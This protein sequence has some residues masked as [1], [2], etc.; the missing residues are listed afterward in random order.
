MNNKLYVYHH[1]GLG[2]HIICNGLIRHLLKQTDEITLFSKSR[3]CDNV[4]RM[5]E[6]L[7]DKL[8][9]VCMKDDRDV[10][11]YIQ[12]K[13][14][15]DCLVVGHHH[16]GNIMKQGYTWDESFYKQL[17]IP[18]IERWNSFFVERNYSDENNLKDKLD[19]KKSYALVHSTD[20][21]NTDR[22]NYEIINK[23]LQLV[24]VIIS[25]SIF[26]Y[27]DLIHNAS[28]IHCVDSS[29]KLLVDS[30]KLDKIPLYFH[31]NY[32]LRNTSYLRHKSQNNW[33][34]I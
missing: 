5:F 7:G 16:L 2:D 22:I 21:T 33:I 18:F 8:S 27:I 17:N 1:L 24:K 13:N 12:E 28:E 26:D 4:K 30:Y 3:N 20:S 6:D 34:E 11:S 10:K 14:I 15:K 31:R 19:I 29:F 32:K 25:K 23:D 9:L